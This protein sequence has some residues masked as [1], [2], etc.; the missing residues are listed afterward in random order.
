MFSMKK[1]LLL[2]ICILLLGCTS[3]AFARR[4]RT[5]QFPMQIGEVILIQSAWEHIQTRHGASGVT[6]EF[7]IQTITNPQLVVREADRPNIRYYLKRVGVRQWVLMVVV[8]NGYIAS[9]YFTHA[10]DEVI[11]KDK[12]K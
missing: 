7:I 6:L 5:P 10:Y 9:A 8:N 3:P 4:V 12:E 2:I 1:S 11:G